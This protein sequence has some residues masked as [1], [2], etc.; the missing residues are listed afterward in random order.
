M[1]I[2][3]SHELCGVYEKANLSVQFVVVH[4]AAHGGAAFYDAERQ[5]MVEKFL[6]NY[7]APPLIDARRAR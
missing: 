3:Q 5:T 6:N 7:S 2:N 1:P 4:G